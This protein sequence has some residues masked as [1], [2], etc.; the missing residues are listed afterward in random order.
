MQVTT[1]PL[2]PLTHTSI[3]ATTAMN[4]VG[5]PG[6][7]ISDRMPG[8]DKSLSQQSPLRWSPS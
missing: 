8:R 6:A 7:A 2:I 3:A 4:A 5:R 1:R